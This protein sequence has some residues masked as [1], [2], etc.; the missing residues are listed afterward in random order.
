MSEPWGIINGGLWRSRRFRPLPP[1]AKVLYVYL[2]TSQLR[3][4]IGIYRLPLL[5]AADDTGLDPARVEGWMRQLCDAGLA[6]FD[7]AE[8][9]VRVR[10][11]E[12][13]NAP[14]GPQEAIGRMLQGFDR[15][16]TSPI[17]LAGFVT[18]AHEV[19]HRAAG[20][21][22]AGEGWKN[23]DVRAKMEDMIFHRLTQFQRLDPV[24]LAAAFCI[25]DIDPADTVFHTIWDRVSP[26]RLDPAE[27]D[28]V[29]DTVWHTP[30]HTRRIPTPI[31]RTQ[32]KTRD[33][34]SLITDQGTQT[35]DQGSGINK[36]KLESERRDAPPDQ[37]E[38]GPSGPR[39]E[40]VRPGRV[41]PP[42]LQETIASMNQA[43]K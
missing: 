16:A 19:L 1:E 5:I 15:I 2:H 42:D 29:S 33:Q 12:L 22:K 7:P 35:R 40:G 3:T 9:L 39:S 18:F 4:A 11:W 26:E 13:R 41:P 24:I 36:S 14:Q 34:R 31:Q 28:R 20:T 43:R 27:V 32:T 8:S 30:P 6:D 10:K 25:A 21:H 37:A 38:P 23:S 17:V